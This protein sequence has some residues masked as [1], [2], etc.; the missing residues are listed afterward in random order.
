MQYWYLKVTDDEGE[1]TTWVTWA[2]TKPYAE[3]LCRRTVMNQG[4]FPKDVWCEQYSVFKHG[5]M[6]NHRK[7][8]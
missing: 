7:I 3:G 4:I 1:V 2:G 6:E 5:D 8:R